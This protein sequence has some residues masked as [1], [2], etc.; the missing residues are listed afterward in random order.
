MT[1]PSPGA[2]SGSGG[3]ITVISMPLERV[4][5]L[6]RLWT[7]GLLRS[8]CGSL[9]GAAAGVALAVALPASLGAFVRASTASMTER[10]IAAIPVD[11]QVQLLV[12]ADRVMIEDAVRKAASVRKAEWV[13]YADVKGLEAAT[14]GTVQ[15]TGPGQ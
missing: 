13:G 8:R 9:L 11:W 10:A 3:W 1:R 6:L 12:G 15:L 2:C 7:F 14:G 4:A 5:K